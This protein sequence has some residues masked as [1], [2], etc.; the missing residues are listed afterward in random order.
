MTIIK[1]NIDWSKYGKTGELL[2]IINMNCITANKLL[3]KTII[4]DR[5]LSFM[6]FIG[7]KKL[8]KIGITIMKKSDFDKLNYQK[9]HLYLVDTC[10]LLLTHYRKVLI[11]KTMFTHDVL[12]NS[13][14]IFIEKVPI[15]GNK[16]RGYDIKKIEE[17]VD[18]VLKHDKTSKKIKKILIDDIVF[19]VN[20]NIRKGTP[21]VKIDISKFVDYIYEKSVKIKLK[22]QEEADVEAEIHALYVQTKNDF[23]QAKKTHISNRGYQC[24]TPCKKNTFYPYC[25]CNTVPY[26]YKGQSYNWDR[27]Q[28]C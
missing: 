16:E 10:K 7:Q 12:I 23:K 26:N 1:L 6:Q 25:S 28:S 22:K 19:S 13:M 2:Y 11:K 9:Q 20:S 15:G 3:N 18:I 5:L 21:N 14:K 8:T 24:I 27:C 17:M 4:S